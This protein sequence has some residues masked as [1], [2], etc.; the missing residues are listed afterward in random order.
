MKNNHNNLG[1]ELRQY[2]VKVKDKSATFFP[3]LLLIAVMI[4]FFAVASPAAILSLSWEPNTEPDLAGYKIYYD[5]NH[6]GSFQNVVDV[7]NVVE[8]TLVGL[9]SGET[10]RFALTA[11]DFFNNESDFSAETDVTIPLPAFKIETGSVVLKDEWVR[12]TYSQ[13]FS[14]PIVVA[15][16]LSFDNGDPATIRIRNIDEYG[17]EIRA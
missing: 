13:S 14:D 3:S 6:S 2:F 9:E 1:W 7:G 4:L 8:Y 12:V 15:N 5:K 17:F 10:Y 11:Y 16:C